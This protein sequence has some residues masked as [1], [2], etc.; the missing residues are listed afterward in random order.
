MNLKLLQQQ[1]FLENINF[2]EQGFLRHIGTCACLLLAIPNL[3]C[4]F[5]PSFNTFSWDLEQSAA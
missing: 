5:L 4:V 2:F 1:L 3:R